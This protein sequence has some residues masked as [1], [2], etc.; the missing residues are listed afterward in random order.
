MCMQLM[1]VLYEL[2]LTSSYLQSMFVILDYRNNKW[3]VLKTKLFIVS[4]DTSYSLALY[5]LVLSSGKQTDTL[6]IYS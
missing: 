2:K 3:H 4:V 5:R 1:Y 6:P